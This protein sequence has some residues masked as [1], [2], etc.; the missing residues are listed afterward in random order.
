MYLKSR[1]SFLS[2]VDTELC[3]TN[4][5]VEKTDIL[6]PSYPRMSK[7]IGESQTFNKLCCE[8]RSYTFS[9]ILSRIVLRGCITVL[10]AQEVSTVAILDTV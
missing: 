10:Y 7:C 5:E 1:K 3:D 9:Q 2:Y 6:G 8:T 4:L